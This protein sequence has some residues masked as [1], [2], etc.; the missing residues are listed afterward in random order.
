MLELAGMKKIYEKGKSD[1]GLRYMLLANAKG[2]DA[3]EQYVANA[4]DVKAKEAAKGE[5]AEFF[6]QAKRNENCLTEPRTIIGEDKTK[7]D[8]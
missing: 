7:E 3:K 5:G 6:R 8:F 4:K 2:V 1:G